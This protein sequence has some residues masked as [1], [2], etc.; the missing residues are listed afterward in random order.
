MFSAVVQTPQRRKFLEF[1][2]PYLS[3]TNVI[4]ALEGGT[5]F[6]NMNGLSGYTIS[7]VEDFSVT[8]FIRHDYP[9]INIIE[10]K[11]ISDALKLVVN[12]NVD[13]YVGDITTT[14][15]TIA[16]EGLTQL[17][18][19]GEAPYKT[20]L[21]MGIRAELPLLASA[22]KKA[23]QSFTEAEKIE[24]S[25]EWLALRIENKQN[26]VVIFEILSIAGFIILVILV[27]VYSLKREVDRRRVDN[28]KIKDIRKGGTSRFIRGGKIE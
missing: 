23:I 11:S 17:V 21:T 24:I 3:L 9:N 19:A 7:Q 14:S 15:Y 18:V 16:A 1:T 8:E 5:I 6:G 27:W 20:S 13:A 25:S 10:T 12:G 26:Y 22:M 2:D 28:E 4:F